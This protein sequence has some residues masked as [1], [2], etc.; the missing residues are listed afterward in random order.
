MESWFTGATV[1]KDRPS[2]TDPGAGAAAGRAASPE[3]E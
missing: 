2:S 1:T 3:R